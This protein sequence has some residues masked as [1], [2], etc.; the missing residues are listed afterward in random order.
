MS[1]MYVLSGVRK[2]PT[3]PDSCV[4]KLG[5]SPDH[6]QSCLLGRGGQGDY[7]RCGGVRDARS[8]AEKRLLD[9]PDLFASDEEY[10][11]GGEM[12]G[13]GGSEEG[14]EVVR[15]AECVQLPKNYQ[16]TGEAVWEEK[17]LMSPFAALPLFMAM[18][19]E[20]RDTLT[21]LFRQYLNPQLHNLTHFSSDASWQEED[22]CLW[23]P[24]GGKVVSQENCISMKIDQKTI[25]RNPI[26]SKIS[27]EEEKEEEI[28]N[29][30]KR[31]EKVINLDKKESA[32]RLEAFKW[33]LEQKKLN[34]V[35]VQE[36]DSR[37]ETSGGEALLQSTLSTFHSLL[38]KN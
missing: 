4:D 1:G 23:S 27:Q 12:K 14:Q 15:G 25:L 2:L 21:P 5:R 6:S 3:D 32:K 30:R 9:S 10:E 28:R 19:K 29:K 7:W 35:R 34:G 24:R 13:A 20:G 26:K 36:D 33:M 18:Q 8:A 37:D 11:A 31:S 38:K 22:F 16:L 17:T